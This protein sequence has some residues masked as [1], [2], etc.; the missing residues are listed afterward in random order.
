MAWIA[1]YAMELTAMPKRHRDDGSTHAQRTS[2]VRK[3]RANSDQEL[4]WIIKNGI[5]FTGMPAFGKVEDS[6]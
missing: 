4:F 5:R 1:T 3:F 6:R 2:R